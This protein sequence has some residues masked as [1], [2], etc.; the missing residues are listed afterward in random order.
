VFLFPEALPDIVMNSQLRAPSENN[1]PPT[2]AV[3]P[4]PARP[5]REPD[6]WVENRP[7]DRWFPRLH[8]GEL[9][10]YRELGLAF[11]LK[12]LRVRY[13][14]T[15][16]GISW[17][18][19][20]PLLAVILFSIVFGRL[21][22]LPTDGIPYPVFNYSAMILWLY[23]SVS[24]A[25][26][27]QSL[28]E[29]RDLVTKVYFPRLVAPVAAAVPGLVDFAIAFVVLVGMLALYGVTPDWAVVLTPAWVLAAVAVVLSVGLPLAAL[30]V[31]YR[32]VR[33]GLPLF[34]QLGLF[35]S[36]VVYSSS[37][38]EGAWKYVYALNPMSTVLDGFRWSV[39]D[40]PAPGP[41]G[42]VS[43]GVVVIVL[44]AGLVYFGR[45]ERSFAD[46]V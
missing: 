9:W 38:V 12:T 20:Q 34:L 17:A 37:L 7:S 33:H 28:V 35:A 46:V 30:N 31:K 36:P 26:A 42:F 21:A 29:T 13:K 1:M 43:L 32:D 24:V 4:V 39:A 10:S 18:V 25:G 41:E 6:D 2:S 44:S 15:V 40:G 45:V 27:A 19:L 16:F 14:Q 22:G 11:A 5:G 3:G 23:V 8:L